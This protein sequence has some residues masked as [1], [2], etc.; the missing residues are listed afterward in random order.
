MKK[1]VLALL[2]AISATCSLHAFAQTRGAIDSIL[3]EKKPHALGLQLLRAS[4]ACGPMANCA[5]EEP[6]RATYGATNPCVSDPLGCHLSVSSYGNSNRSW[7]VGGAKLN[8]Q[9]GRVT[10]SMGKHR[11][12][13]VLTRAPFI[14]GSYRLG[15]NASFAV[16]V[17]RARVGVDMPHNSSLLYFSFRMALH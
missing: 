1:L 2:F 6:N 9:V 12:N 3:T 4:D 13:I 14:E 16:G 15:T 17:L 8:T 7:Y 10:F 5:V 11:D